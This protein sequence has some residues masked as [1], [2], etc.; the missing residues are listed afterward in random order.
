VPIKKNLQVV[1]SVVELRLDP[2]QKS[3]TIPQVAA[4][5]GLTHWQVRMAIW[6]GRLAAKRVGKSLI[7]LRQDVDAFLESLPTV[8]A[9]DAEWLAKRQ[10]VR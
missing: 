6:E 9:N 5:S 1:P 4:Y 7:V 2:T 8:S 3:F 10:A